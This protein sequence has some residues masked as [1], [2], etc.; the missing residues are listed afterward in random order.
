MSASQAPTPS[1]IKSFYRDFADRIHEKRLQ[2]PYPLRRAVHFDIYSSVLQHIG[3]GQEVLD[4]GCGEGGLSM[5]MA[6]CGAR[7]TAAD[8]SEPNIAEARRLRDA[9]G[10]PEDVLRF[11]LGDAEALP[12]PDNAFDVVVSNHVLEHLPD[13]D[14]GLAE[15]RRLTRRTALIAVPTCLN[16]CAWALLG[17]ANYWRLSLRAPFSLALGLARVISARILGR[18]GVDEGYVGQKLP[19][20]F[21]FPDRARRRIEAAGFRVLDQRAQSLCLPFVPTTF[22]T[23]RLARALPWAGI[24]TLFVLEK[25]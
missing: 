16:P 17:G 9:A 22:T 2:S 12:F 10:L 5:L 1:Q 6:G 13:F 7:V 11:E 4:A 25:V 19:H 8:L 3:P 20:V 21:R 24:G 14:A 18:E 23:P 15:I